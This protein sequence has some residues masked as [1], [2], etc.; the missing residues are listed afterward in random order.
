MTARIR[1]HLVWFT[2]A[3]WLALPWPGARA[4]TRAEIRRLAIVDM[5]RTLEHAVE[6]AVEPWSVQVVA[7]ASPAPGNTMPASAE[8]A[9][10]IAGETDVGAVV[11]IAGSEASFALWLYDVDSRKVVVLELPAPPPYDEPTAA[12][13][14]LTIK[15]LLRHSMV[16]P[17]QERLAVPPPPPA[18]A[19]AEAHETP[20]VV[21]PR[22]A[23]ARVALEMF[24]GVRVRGPVGQGLERRTGFAGYLVPASLGGAF[25]VGA[26]LDSGSGVTV[27]EPDFV[28]S[29]RETTVALLGRAQ[30]GLGSRAS[31][32][33]NL[34]GAL[35]LSALDGLPTGSA[36][37]VHQRRINPS[38]EGAL[39]VHVR[40]AGDLALGVAA[41]A[42]LLA[43]RQ[44][45][46]VGDVVVLELPLLELDV[47]LQLGSSF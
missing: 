2:L 17:E 20:P 36:A 14:A 26:A 16:A 40:V 35:H 6:T 21:A 24:A 11:W 32:S 38:L 4:Q 25:G 31:L 1:P 9:R 44:R 10:H 7:L 45:Y 43:R 18:N 29:Y 30:F 3:V 12:G 15:T 22:P 42:S 41:R 5:D 33:G 23:G 47:A 8:R 28:G 13:V 39:G 19:N 27:E 46:L 37:A 34:G